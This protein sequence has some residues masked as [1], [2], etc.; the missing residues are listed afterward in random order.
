MAVLT[1]YRSF[2]ASQSSAMCSN[3]LH[4]TSSRPHGGR[5]RSRSSQNIRRRLLWLTACRTIEVQEIYHWIIRR[6]TILANKCLELSH[7]ATTGV[8]LINASDNRIIWQW[9]ICFT[10]C[11]CRRACSSSRLVWCKGR[12]PPGAVSVLIVWTEWTL[13]TALLW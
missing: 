11:I 3:G 5:G 1:T 10:G 7:S 12:Q 6:K 2:D 4:S 8:T 13:A 9:W